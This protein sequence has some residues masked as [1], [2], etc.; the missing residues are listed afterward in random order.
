MSHTRKIFRN[1][2]S[3]LANKLATIL[4]SFISRKLFLMFLT[5]ELLGLNSL[6]SDLLGLLNLADMGLAIAVQYNLFKP[7]AE[8]D[9]EKIGRILNATNRIYNVIGS[10][11]IVAGLILSFFIQYFIKENPYELCRYVFFCPQADIYAGL[12]GSAHLLRS[13][14]RHQYRLLCPADRDHCG[15]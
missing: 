4:L 12:R 2:I 15:V 6:F 10:G 7:I 9:H 1:S 8:K 14:H 5:E 13:G 3:S 11:I